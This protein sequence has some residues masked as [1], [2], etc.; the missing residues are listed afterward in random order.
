MSTGKA[1]QLTMIENYHKHTATHIRNIQE[2]GLK[3]VELLDSFPKEATLHLADYG[4]ADGQNSM[5]W[6]RLAAAKAKERCQRL[7][8]TFSDQ[9]AENEQ[10]LRKALAT[11][12]EFWEC[13]THLSFN[14]KAGSFFQQIL[15][16]NS[17]DIA[18]SS[19]AIHWLSPVS[20]SFNTSLVEES[21]QKVEIQNH[22]SKDLFLFYQARKNELKPH[23]YLVLSNI[24]E[25]QGG[26][27]I[28]KNHI[29]ALHS[30][31][32]EMQIE[33]MSIPI[34]LRTLSELVLPLNRLGLKQLYAEEVVIPCS[35]YAEYMA[36]SQSH[37]DASHEFGKQ[38]ANSCKAWGYSS[39]ER[40]SN[41]NRAQEFFNQLA[42][43]FAN[44]P[45]HYKMDF[46]V[47]HLVVQNS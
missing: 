25:H 40:A 2:I 14:Y 12:Q 44:D 32:A 11:D 34:Y 27:Y 18:F 10:V 31:A 39:V 17:I 43:Q 16:D 15:P 19:T 7:E 3:I 4:C 23:G 38:M 13:N 6:I 24:G 46:I 47:H 41:Q 35:Y 30:L 45:L 21:A 9:S 29:Q 1:N 26:E 36:E 33:N 8:I 28:A 5:G 37:Q 20:S 22:A 42:M